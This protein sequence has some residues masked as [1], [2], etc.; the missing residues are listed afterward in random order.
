MFTLTNLKNNNRFK[1]ASLTAILLLVAGFSIMLY[2]TLNIHN[3]TQ[4]LLD[5]SKLTAEEMWSYEGSLQWWSNTYA[6]I[7]PVTVTM[8]TAGLV[9]LFGPPAWTRI[10]QKHAIR[11][12]THQL[13]L[14]SREKF[15]IE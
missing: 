15:E 9:T 1:L 13:E 2:T 7:F 12:F 4:L 14:A 5:S 11:T 3:Y 10:Q 6:T 8:I